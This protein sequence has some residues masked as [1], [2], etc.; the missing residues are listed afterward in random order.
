MIIDLNN[1][2]HV[3]LLS[4]I[5]VIWTAVNVFAVTN[6]ET[7]PIHFIAVAGWIFLFVGV[8]SSLVDVI[9]SAL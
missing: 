3:F 2:A 9:S 4:L 8:A 6:R 5:I 7:T 1:A